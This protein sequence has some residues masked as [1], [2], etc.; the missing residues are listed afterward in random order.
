MIDPRLQKLAEVIVRY[1]L[2][3]VPGD[4]FRINGTDL[5]GPLIRAVYREA[6]HA[7]AMVTVELDMDG[8]NEILLKEGSDEQLAYVSPLWEHGVEYFTT[9]LVIAGKHNTKALSS[10][11]PARMA[12]R[13]KAFAKLGERFMERAAKN[14]IRWCYTLFP[15][16]ASAQDA[17]MSLTD[18]ED[19]VFG[20]GLLDHADPVA[21]WQAVEAKQQKIVDFLSKH[22]EIHIVAPGT[23]IIYRVGG[24]TWLNAAG[25]FNFPDGEVFTGPLETSVNGTV[26]FTYPA[27]YMANEVEDVRLTFRDGRVVDASAGRGRAF[28]DSMLDMDDGSR[29]LGEVAFGLNYGI[30]RFTRNILFDEKIGGT[31]HMALGASYPESGG[32]NKSGLHWDMICDL[33]EGQVFADGQLCYEHGQFIVD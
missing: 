12:L 16:Q 14:E 33:R 25:R 5:C 30:K 31:M 28:L 11:D 19:F 22:D 6:I 13:G 8:L 27:I 18:Y 17:S 32:L 23:D 1:S 3:I 20:A 10:I 24:R 21:S 4:T 2:K 29:M 7:G 9:D 26:N 15:T